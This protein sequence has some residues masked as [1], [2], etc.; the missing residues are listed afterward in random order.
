[1]K[2]S[3]DLFCQSSKS[4]FVLT[5]FQQIY[6]P[7]S[8]KVA[9][10]IGQLR[11]GKLLFGG[12]STKALH[13]V[14]HAQMPNSQSNL[15]WVTYIINRQQSMLAVKWE[16]DLSRFKLLKTTRKL[17]RTMEGCRTNQSK[18]LRGRLITTTLLLWEVPNHHILETLPRIS[19]MAT[20]VPS[21]VVKVLKSQPHLACH[22]TWTE[23]EVLNSNN[24][25]N[26]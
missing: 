26:I 24:S 5:S 16:R 4:Y 6:I 23:K 7:N 20:F 21:K 11:I 19:C 25:A 12:H 18:T 14:P 15:Y 8:I 13:C 2:T 10:G 22:V 17:L 3:V 9:L 1:M